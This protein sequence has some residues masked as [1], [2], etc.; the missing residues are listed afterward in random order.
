MED[1]LD[2]D[3]VRMPALLIPSKHSEHE[4]IES[5]LGG[6]SSVSYPN[7]MYSVTCG[8]VALPIPEVQSDQTLSLVCGRAVLLWNCFRAFPWEG[9][10]GMTVYSH[11]IN[12]SWL[13]TYKQMTLPCSTP[14]ISRLHVPDRGNQSYTYHM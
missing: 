3:S 14:R 8:E 5:C 7:Q 11:C 4:C 6:P 9:K 1:R 2:T 10:E 13:D 12:P